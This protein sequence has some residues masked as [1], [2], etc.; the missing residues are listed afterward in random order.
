MVG[1]RPGQQT[2][3]LATQ[4]VTLIRRQRI[5]FCSLSE[6]EAAVRLLQT[7]VERRNLTLPLH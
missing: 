1:E 6:L 7:V 3:R 5:L 4:Q 2:D